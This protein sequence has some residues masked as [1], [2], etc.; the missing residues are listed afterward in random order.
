VNP[1]AAGL[2]CS[3]W[4][5]FLRCKKS[6]NR[7][8]RRRNALRALENPGLNPRHCNPDFRIEQDIIVILKMSRVTAPYYL[9]VI[10]L[11]AFV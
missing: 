1:A 8:S 6:R 5:C 4:F 9:K 3:L 7:K 11:F 10:H 2:S